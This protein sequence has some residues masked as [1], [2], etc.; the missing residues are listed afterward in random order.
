MS[1]FDRYMIH[2][3]VGTDEKL[4]GLNHNERLCHVVG[5]LAVAAKS[6]LRG[7]LIVGDAEATAAQIGRRAATTE[8]VARAT[9]EKLVAVGI[10]IR[11][12]EVGALRVHNWENFNPAP[13]NDPTNAERQRRWRERNGARNATSNAEVTAP[14]VEVEVEVEI[15]TN[16][17]VDLDVP[18]DVRVVFDAWLVAT[19][20]DAA[21][22]KL[23]PERR[24]II[25]K[26]LGSHGIDVCLRAVRNIG[27]D[28]WARGANDRGQRFDDISHALGSHERIERWSS[29]QKPVL[30][31]VTERD[32]RRDRDRAALRLL[33]QGEAS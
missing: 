33:M 16:N 7:Y 20:R 22:T 32:E 12:D 30:T 8:K 23:N 5:V 15:P 27:A 19:E 11:D 6:P 29:V 9:I 10:L 17:L 31:K 3:D 18:T 26:A 2:V 4:A 25:V 24:R 21:R 28:A 13:K 14:E 1:R